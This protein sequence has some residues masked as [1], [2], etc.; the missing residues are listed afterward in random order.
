MGLDETGTVF[1]PCINEAACGDA[2]CADGYT[3]PTCTEC[4][5]S[6]MIL[7]DFECMH[8]PS[9]VENVGAF[10]TGV[11]LYLSYL[12]YKVKK[13]QSGTAPNQWGTFYK[14]VLTTCQ[15]NAIALTYSF[16]WSTVMHGYLEAQ[17]SVTSFG[18]AYFE[19]SCFK[20][21]S[22]LT[23]AERNSFRLETTFYIVLPLV[24]VLF[25]GISVYV[26]IVYCRPPSVALEQPERN[27]QT[28]DLELTNTGTCTGSWGI[29]ALRDIP[30]TECN[31]SSHFVEF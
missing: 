15:T 25:A 14:V 23:S 26:F 6:S 20:T 13:K 10:I 4:T 30:V 12:S 21:D 18:T 16:D 24:L 2:G 8:C 27:A 11:F 29:R 5:N 1:F 17:D 22:T 3:G 31:T 7:S 19:L 9:M 28:Q